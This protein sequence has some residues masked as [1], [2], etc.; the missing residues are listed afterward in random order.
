MFQNTNCSE[1]NII[2][3]GCPAKRPSLF[4]K[5]NILK[6]LNLNKS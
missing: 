3:T 1:E 2:A 4:V 5:I 6:I